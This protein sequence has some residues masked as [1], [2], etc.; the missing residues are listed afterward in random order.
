MSS[1]DQDAIRLLVEGDLELSSGDI[2]AL[3]SGG[4]P[5]GEEEAPDDI[6]DLLATSSE[7]HSVTQRITGQYAEILVTEL[8]GHPA[9]GLQARDQAGGG[10]LGQG[11]G[12]GRIL[13]NWPRLTLGA[14]F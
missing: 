12:L 9:G 8:P 7:L 3:L 11:A 6:S 4:A 1:S 10:Q 2:A 13:H 5:E 14:Q